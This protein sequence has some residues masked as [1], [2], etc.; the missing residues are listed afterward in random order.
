MSHDDE[1]SQ[2]KSNKKFEDKMTEEPLKP[3]DGGWGKTFNFNMP[4]IFVITF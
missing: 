2:L 4:T 1:P 3:L